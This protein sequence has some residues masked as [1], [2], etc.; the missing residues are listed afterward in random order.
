MQPKNESMKRAIYLIILVLAV[1]VLSG[2]TTDGGT[3]AVTRE[4]DMFIFQQAAMS[5]YAY[6]L[7]S[8]TPK[9]PNVS[10]A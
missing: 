5:I 2:C 10:P 7:P 3:K 1:S 6:Q 4:G 9:R 8:K